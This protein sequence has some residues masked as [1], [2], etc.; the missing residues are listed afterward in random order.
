MKRDEKKAAKLL[1]QRWL[2]YFTFIVGVWMLLATAAVH[3]AAILELVDSF[4]KGSKFFYYFLACFVIV[5]GLVGC[6]YQPSSS[7]V[8]F[9][10]LLILFI[11]LVSLVFPFR[12]KMEATMNKTINETVQFHYGKNP[13]ATAMFDLTQKSLGCCGSYGPQSWAVSAFNGFDG[14]TT[15]TPPLN[16]TKPQSC[17]NSKYMHY[18]PDGCIDWLKRHFIGTF[19]LIFVVFFFMS[20]VFQMNIYS[21]LFVS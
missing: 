2:N 3:Y 12:Y 14:N 11:L 8:R 19:H 17:Y 20:L 4:F 1:F 10:G 9:T 15:S 18:Y 7:L 13:N 16:F 5:Y 6:C 21:T